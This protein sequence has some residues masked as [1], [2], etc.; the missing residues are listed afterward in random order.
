M[1]IEIRSLVN[2]S[3]F[4]FFGFLQRTASIGNGWIVGFAVE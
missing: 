1:D 3:G 2:C 4:V